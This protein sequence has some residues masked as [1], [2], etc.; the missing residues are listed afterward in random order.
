MLWQRQDP[1]TPLGQMSREKYDSKDICTPM[2]I[3]TQ[4]II[5]KT[6]K[7]SKCPSIEKQIKMW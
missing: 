5:V 1:A 4:F 7:Q 3:A 2:F 6:W